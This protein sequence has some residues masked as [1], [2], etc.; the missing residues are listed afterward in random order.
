MCPSSTS[1]SRA[2]GPY[3]LVWRAVLFLL[4]LALLLAPWEAMFWLS[5]ECL[6]FSMVSLWQDRRPTGLF[7]RRYFSQDYNQYKLSRMADKEP[8]ILVA[9]SSRVLQFRDFM[10]H[11]LGAKFY[12][13]GRLLVCVNDLA[14]LAGMMAE[15]KT[16]R[17]DSLIVGVDPWW[18]YP[19]AA[20]RKVLDQK[21][22][23]GSYRPAAHLTALREMISN[24]GVGLLAK[25]WHFPLRSKWC[26]YPALGYMAAGGHGF[27][28]DGSFTY[29]SYLK[30]FRAEPIYRD[31]VSPAILT[32]IQKGTNQ[33]R[34]ADSLGE[35]ELA[36]LLG[37][38]KSLT[39]QGVRVAV[40]LPPF[41]GPV[42]A[43]LRSDK[44]YRGWYLDYWSKLP[45]ALEKAGIPWFGRPTPKDWGLDDRYML[46]GFHPGEVL[47]AA[48][49]RDW[50]VS[51]PRP[52]LLGRVDT[53]RLGGLRLTPGVLPVM[54]PDCD[55]PR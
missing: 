42:D 34:P 6:P 46:D 15:G 2:K 41:A 5:G 47:I 31:R 28:A 53:E 55:P 27:R 19:K 48:I 52:G 4:P 35:T 10:F 17:P 22:G 24:G 40:F 3:A 30:D 13:A 16:P 21:A 50:L 36:E 25:L 49:V 1:S 23:D 44:R 39:G 12:N 8:G 7:G 38:I 26:G 11:P 54:F 9:G 20:A 45:R 32:R 14:C 51:K 43:K 18:L 37:A 33:F 29:Y